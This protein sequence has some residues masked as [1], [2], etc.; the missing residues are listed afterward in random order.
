MKRAALFGLTAH[1]STWGAASSAQEA[2]GFNRT[3]LPIPPEQ[4]QGAIGLNSKDSVSA[5]PRP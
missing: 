2:D 5:F 1:L 3:V 4:F